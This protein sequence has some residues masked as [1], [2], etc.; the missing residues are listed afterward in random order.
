[1]ARSRTWTAVVAVVCAFTLTAGLAACSSSDSSSGGGDTTGVT[2]TTIKIAVAVSDLDGLRAAGI[3]LAPALTTGNLSKRVT[4]YFDEWNAAGGI[5]GRKIESVV[6]TWDPVKPATAQK[7][8]DDATINNPVFA[9]IAPSGLGA[10]YVECIAAAG[11][12]IFFGDV[13]PQS[14]HDTGWL[15]SIQPSSEVSASSGVAS[16]IKAGQIAKGAAVGILAGNGPEHVAA[17][18]AAKTQL[19]ANGNKVTV[20][21][22]NTLQGDPGI[23]NTESAAAVNTFKAANLANVVIALQF[24]ASGG[25]WD[26][27]AGNGW[28]FTFLDVA[29]SMCTAYG[30]KSLKPS[31]VGG[32]CYTAMG[33]SVTSEGKLR[34]ETDFEKAC[35]AKFDALS[36]NDFGGAKSYS[37]IPSGETRTLPDGQKVSSDY[38]PNE[39]TFVNMLKPALEKAGKK[40]TRESFMKAVRGLGEVN[41]ALG[42]NGKG[43]QEPGK[44]WVATVVHGDK[45]TAAPTGTAKNANGTY[46]NCPVDIQCWV[47]VDATWYP[48]TK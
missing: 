20:A 9:V 43:S 19:E 13:A 28:K 6:M 4:S 29:S 25:F 5:N 37:G 38:P 39:C 21:Q 27:A 45:L 14:A 42:S 40:L 48:I 7:V 18:A 15:T 10:K 17:V 1:M 12:P 46:N 22:I 24:T 2:D 23:Q 16:A 26:N 32:I 8:C 30:A 11:V 35:R 31:A 47:P 36:V 34:V 3:S 41:V 44:T 33:D